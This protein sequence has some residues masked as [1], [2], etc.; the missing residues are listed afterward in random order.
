MK[1][2]D[3]TIAGWALRSSLGRRLCTFLTDSDDWLARSSLR[4]PK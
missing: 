4:N 2:G 3:E 1:S